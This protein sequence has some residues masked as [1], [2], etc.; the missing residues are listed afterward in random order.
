MVCDLSI[1][2]SQTGRYPARPFR[3]DEKAALQL[4]QRGL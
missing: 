2:E 4:L 1:D 3:R